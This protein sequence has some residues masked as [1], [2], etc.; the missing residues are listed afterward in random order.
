M[1]INTNGVPCWKFSKWA[2]DEPSSVFSFNSAKEYYVRFHSVLT[3]LMNE[4]GIKSGGWFYDFRSVL[5]KYL[6]K[7]NGEWREVYAPN[8][9]LLRKAVYGRIDKIVEIKEC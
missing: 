3:T 6:F 1:V 7:Q 4:G 2:K 5:K 9:T 8:K